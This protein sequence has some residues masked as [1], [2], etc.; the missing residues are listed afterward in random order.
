[1]VSISGP[2]VSSGF[3]NTVQRLDDNH[4]RIRGI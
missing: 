1:V 2:P 3:S 4:D